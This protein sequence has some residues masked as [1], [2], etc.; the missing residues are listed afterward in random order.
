MHIRELA[1][2]EKLTQAFRPLACPDSKPLLFALLILTFEFGS[3][4]WIEV[5]Q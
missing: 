3:A 4:S 1:N 5:E 2:P